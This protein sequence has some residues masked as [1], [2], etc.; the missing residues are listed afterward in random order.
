MIRENPGKFLKIKTASKWKTE[1][2]VK[3]AENAF[4][5]FLNSNCIGTSFGNGSLKFCIKNSIRQT[6]KL[7]KS[8]SISK[9][10]PYTFGN[11]SLIFIFCKKKSTEKLVKTHSSTKFKPDAHVRQ[12]S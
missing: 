3:I 2:I 1:T 12:K 6:E 7:V 11:G 9:F 5:L 10:K 4:K 8:H